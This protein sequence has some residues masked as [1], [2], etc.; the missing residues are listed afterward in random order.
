M[1]EVFPKLKQKTNLT[2]EDFEVRQGGGCVVVTHLWGRLST[3]VSD[4][5]ISSQLSVD[6]NVFC[7]TP[8]DD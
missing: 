7:R 8:D 4:P 5:E 2:L 6:E 1:N 3:A